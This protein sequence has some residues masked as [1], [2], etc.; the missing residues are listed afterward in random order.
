MELV[1]CRLVAPRKSNAAAIKK[2]PPRRDRWKEFWHTLAELR[3]FCPTAQ[4]VVVRFSALPDTMLGHCVRRAKRFL[5]RLNAQMDEPQA[6]D[7][8][9]HEW[10]HAMAWSFSL[11]A[12]A[13]RKG[14]TPEEFD[15][16]S[17]DE[18][19]GCSYSRAWRVYTAAMQ[20]FDLAQLTR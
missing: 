15:A 9:V 8:L 1:C 2:A 16:V 11:E 5:I 12:L 14:T 20:K 17:H 19:W 3:A 7:V 18:T 4:P 6:C 13:N 10:A